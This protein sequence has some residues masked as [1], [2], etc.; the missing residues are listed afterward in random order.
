MKKKANKADNKLKV[1]D[2]LH[3]LDENEKDV[4]EEICTEYFAGKKINPQPD[5]IEVKERDFVKWW[6]EGKID[7][8]EAI[9]FYLIN[10][11]FD[12]LRQVFNDQS[13]SQP[14]PEVPEVEDVDKAGDEENKEEEEQK[15]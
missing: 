12:S 10:K 11:I 9:K 14:I 4:I 1:S 13:S 2:L 15:G 7:N 3:D 6:S 8:Y 5:Q